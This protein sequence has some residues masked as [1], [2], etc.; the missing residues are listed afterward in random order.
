[1][2][3]L[4]FRTVLDLRKITQI[5]HRVLYIHCSTLPLAPLPHTVSLLLTSCASVVH[6]LHPTNQHGHI[7]INYNPSLHEGSLFVLYGSLGVEKCIQTYTH[8]FSFIQNDGFTTLNSASPT[9][10]SP[11]FSH[12]QNPLALS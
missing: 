10:P 1:M 8:H 7:T 2:N 5:V 11:L 4:F 3:R 9:H 12:F 6:S